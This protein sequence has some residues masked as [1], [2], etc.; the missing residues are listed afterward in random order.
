[1]T[2]AARRVL[3][4]A[5]PRLPDGPLVVALSGGADSAVAAWAATRQD[6]LRRVRAVFVDHGWEHSA[7]MRCAAETVA[8]ALGIPLEVIAA[9]PHITETG[10]RTARLACLADAAAGMAIVTG[11]HLDDTAE[12]IVGNLLRGAGSAGLAGIPAARPPFVRPLIDLPGEVVRAAACELRLPFCDDPSNEDLRHFRTRIRRGVM[13]ALVSAAP[14]VRDALTRTARTLTADDEALER[15]A[16]QFNLAVEPGAVRIPAGVLMTQ[17]PAVA[18]R[19][20]RRA[21]RLV[22]PPYAGSA[23]DVAKVL[24]AVTGR[25]SELAGGVRCER[26]GAFVTLSRRERV[27]APSPVALDVPG[28]VAFGSCALRITRSSAGRSPVRSPGRLRLDPALGDRLTVRAAGV[29]ERIAIPGGTKPVRE[30]MAEAGVPARLRSGWPV[31][32]VHGKIAAVA[33][34]R[35]A[36]WAL[37]DPS[38]D[39]ILELITERS[40]C[41]TR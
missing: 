33:G 34:A 16:A 10:A 8:E 38:R 13:P 9:E 3:A 41:W 25:T 29:G 24:Q 2:G 28:A 40:S 27:A 1:M 39:C 4:A 32:D 23:A 21:I 18:A 5:A 19:I 6:P 17:P 14:A 7:T 22:N 31:I 11:H 15:C 35:T 30:T 36:A 20:V 26:E 37:P 12:T